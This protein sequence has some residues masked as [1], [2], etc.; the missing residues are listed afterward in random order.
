MLSAVPLVAVGAVLLFGIAFG[1]YETVCMAA[2][3][4]FADARIAATMFAII[5][6]VGNIGIGLGS[7]LA[8]VLVAGVGFAGVFAAFGLIN[9]AC[10]PLVLVVFRRKAAAQA[11]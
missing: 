6:A 3:M 7:P 10:V 1:Y 8:G 11:A 2:G 4:D 5:M 9:L